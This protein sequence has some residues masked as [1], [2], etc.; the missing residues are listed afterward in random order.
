MARVSAFPPLHMGRVWWL[1][2]LGGR[3]GN[4]EVLQRHQAPTSDPFMSSGE[5]D[6][7]G[8]IKAT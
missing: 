2:I 4:D 8:R 3:G 1:P 7:V 5:R 6:E